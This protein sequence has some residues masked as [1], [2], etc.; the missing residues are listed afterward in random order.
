M[1][2][3][4]NVLQIAALGLLGFGSAQAADSMV[5]GAARRLTVEQY[6]RVIAD[7]FGPTI[8][9][10]GRFD[11]DVRVD[12]LIEVGAAQVSVSSTSLAQ[13]DAMA[14][15]IAAQVVNEENRLT[16]LPCKPASATAPDDACAGKFLAKVGASLFRRPL[17]PAEIDHQVKTAARATET[18]KDFYFGLSLTLASMLTAPEFLFR[19]ESVEADPANRGGYRLDSAGKATRLA[20][21]LWNGTPDAEL[22][23]AADKG[24]LDTPKG[25]EKQVNRMMASARLKDGIRAFF[26]DMLQLSGMDDVMKD[27][28]LFPKFSSQ[29]ATE[30]RE[31]TLR[32]IVSVVTAPKGDYR[33]IFTTKKTFLTPGLASIYKVP[34]AF[35]APIGAP[36]Y[37][38]PYEFKPE[39]PRAGILVQT[40]FV[41]MNS[42][43]GRSSPTL[44]GK[45]LREV[46]LCQ[47]VPA[48]PADVNFTIV[49]DTSN[50]IYKTARDRL[51]AHRTNPVCGG[52]H[53]LIDPM[54]LALENFDGGGAFRTTENGVKID[55]SGEVDGVKFADAAGLGQAIHDNQAS[56]SCVVQRLTAYGLGR[57]PKKDETWIDAQKAAFIKGGYSVPGLMRSLVLSPEFYRAIPNEIKAAFNTP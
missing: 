11:P 45:A 31:Q 38:Q 24:E 44:R 30:A 19:V 9:I 40:S 15:S 2:P 51:I 20:F 50:P 5:P 8:K 52:C 42:H 13:Y 10:G 37:W 4:K 46:L 17:T 12:G 43:P 25:L 16:M 27:G 56:A 39:D 49:Q 48:P 3:M 55:T 1:K 54:G 33:D 36:D 35:E 32:T 34:L 23:R 7:T 21:F 22:L 28:T 29:M 57:T 26:D 6:T 18:V 14:R 53:K 47:K 41:T